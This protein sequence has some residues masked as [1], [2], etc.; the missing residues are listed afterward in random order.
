[1]TTHIIAK[2]TY[3]NRAY[4]FEKYQNDI[5]MKSLKL[6]IWGTLTIFTLTAYGQKTA[7]KNP[8][9]NGIKLIHKILTS[10]NTLVSKGGGAIK[11]AFTLEN[12]FSIFMIM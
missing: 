12:Q 4:T 2:Y 5:S 6:F 11:Q 9:P 7:S 8:D 10:I 1:M 3:T